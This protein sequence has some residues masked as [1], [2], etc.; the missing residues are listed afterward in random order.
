MIEDD[1]QGHPEREKYTYGGVVFIYDS[2]ANREVTTFPSR[3]FSSDCSGTKCTKPIMLPK[4]EI[5]LNAAVNRNR[6]MLQIAAAKETWT[7]HSVLVVDMSGSMRRDDVNGARCRS[8]GVWLSLARDWIKAPLDKGARTAT[9]LISVVL[10]AATAKCVI[11]CQPTD[12]VLYNSF[13]EMREWRTER[14]EGPGNYMPALQMAE[15]LLMLNTCG[16][17]SLSLLFFSDGKPSDHGDFAGVAGKIASKFGRRLSCTCIGMAEQG[18]NFSTL[19]EMVR[20]VASFGAIATFGQ[21]S[22]DSDSL[23]NIISSLASSLTSSKTEMTDLGTR[24]AKTVRVDV[25]R[26]KHG[27]PDDVFLTDDWW[28]YKNESVSLFWSWS[29]KMNDFV[30]IF[31]WRCDNCWADCRESHIVCPACQA[32]CFCSELCRKSLLRDH[33]AN[34]PSLAAGM[35]KG[36]IIHRE[37]P[38]FSVGV[39][40]TIFGEGAERMVHKFRFLN[41]RMEFTGPL[42]VAK[43]SRFVDEEASYEQRLEYHRNFMRTQA[44]ASEMA[45]KFNAAIEDLSKRLPANWGFGSS[46]CP[47]ISFLEPMVVEVKDGKLGDYCILIEPMLEVS[48]YEKFSNNMG[49]VKGQKKLDSLVQS[50]G[51]LRIDEAK[52]DG[53]PLGAIEEGS[54]SDSEEE[55]GDCGEELFDE[56]HKQPSRSGQAS[57]DYM[58]LDSDVPH[59]FSHF[60]YEKSKGQLMVVDLQGVFTVQRDNSK[61]YQLTD[62]VIHKKK[63]KQLKA[64]SFGRTDRGRKGMEA[65]FATHVCTDLC[66]LLGLHNNMDMASDRLRSARCD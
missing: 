43:E 60:T 40:R 38:S 2:E 22:L 14:P 8:D 41:Q 10:M 4:A 45:D 29:Y 20:E 30:K 36:K 52:K 11:R 34:C 1:P 56:K 24:K 32:V 31:D 33:Q 55:D 16:S 54:E 7:S 64:W 19:E 13:I 42:M 35:R 48:R 12:W 39:R 62:P 18:E 37:V 17:C 15:S 21:P 58:C 25:V 47:R 65:F 66:K 57:G 63:S 5:D 59:V 51:R 26:E 23:S 50:I 44:I 27:T 61:L 9:Y 53:A 49:Y 3:D 6:T 28:A 46:S